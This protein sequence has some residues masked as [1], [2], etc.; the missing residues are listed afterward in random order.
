MATEGRTFIMSDETERKE[1]RRYCNEVY[2]WGCEKGGQVEIRKIYK[3]RTLSQNNYL[4][5]L[6]SYFA[7][8][9]GCSLEDAKYEF[10]KKRYNSD[11]FVKTRIHNGR[12]VKYVRSSAGLDRPEMKLAIER[13]KNKVLEEFGWPLPDAEDKD[14]IREAKK[15]IRRYMEFL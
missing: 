5:L 9:Y 6:C 15:E 1:F 13:F 12:E 7:S 4:H 11:I 3:Q 2:L 8:Q 14:F 10:F